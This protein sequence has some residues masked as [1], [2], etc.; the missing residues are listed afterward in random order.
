MF[1]RGP[2][3]GA[4]QFGRRAGVTQGVAMSDL[5]RALLLCGFVLLLAGAG[6]AVGH[7]FG[8]GRL[9]GNV[10]L[11]IGPVRIWTPIA[12][13]IVVSIVLTIVVNL[14]GRR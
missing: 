9:P 13:C 4:L 14:V 8:L 10:D 5:A 7:R 2:M 3:Y 11:E 12:T 6:L 1:A